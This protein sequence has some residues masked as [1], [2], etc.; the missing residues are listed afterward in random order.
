MNLAT[1]NFFK[2]KT[3]KSLGEDA[4]LTLSLSSMTLVNESIKPFFY[5]V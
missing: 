5:C 1:C 3:E 4:L 2:K